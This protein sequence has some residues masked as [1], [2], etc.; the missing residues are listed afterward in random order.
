MKMKRIIRVGSRESALAMT[1]SKW[2]INEIKMK[3]PELEFEL[4]GIKTKGDILLDTRLDKIGGKGLFIKELEN[5]LLNGSI[6]IAVHSLK[7]M[8]AEIPEELDIVTFS[9]REDPRD[10]LVTRDGRS[11]YD[12]EEG[13]I[14]GTS[15]VRR[16]LQISAIRSDFKFK[17]LRGNV[18][19]R[20][21][22]LVNGEYDAI[23]LAAAGLKR[24]GNAEA[25]VWPFPT[26]LMIPAVGQGILAVEARKNDDVGYLFDSV[27]SLESTFS[28]RAERAFMIRLNG[29]CTTPMAAHAKISGD[30]MEVYGMLAKENSRIV[31]KQKVEGN[32]NDAARLGEI[33]AENL[34]SQF[35]LD[36]DLLN[37]GKNS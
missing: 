18:I 4:V 25:K 14:I 28:A 35:Q 12:L 1:Q 23:V 9:E 36:T 11:I 2:V 5:E 26:D 21:N 16:E 20:I 7:D 30:A 32:K 8:P 24:L 3:H 27:H 22:K 10:V 19:T 13:S 31:E 33:L 6:D 15:S 17:M 37:G 29:G 34:L